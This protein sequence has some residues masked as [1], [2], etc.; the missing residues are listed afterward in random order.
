MV[1]RR[2]DPLDLQEQ[3]QMLHLAL[4]TPRKPPYVVWAIA[5]D[6]E[7]ASQPL[8]EHVPLADRRRLPGHVDQPLKRASSAFER[9]ESPSA[10]RIRTP[11]QSLISSSKAALDPLPWTRNSAAFAH[12]SS[13]WLT[14]ALLTTLAM[15]S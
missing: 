2:R 13:T 7:E 1:V 14:G 11:V 4:Q 12:A 10:S 15:A 9:S 5:V 8:V 3:P 6:D